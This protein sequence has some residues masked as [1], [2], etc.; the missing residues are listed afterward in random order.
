MTAA[1]VVQTSLGTALNQTNRREEER[2]RTILYRSTNISSISTRRM[3]TL[4]HTSPHSLCRFPEVASPPCAS[5]A[6]ISTCQDG[7][8]LRL[9]AAL[10]SGD[11]SSRGVTELNLSLQSLGSIGAGIL[12]SMLSRRSSRP[13][14]NLCLASAQLGD[15]RV[16]AAALAQGVASGAHTGLSST[17]H[18][19]GEWKSQGAEL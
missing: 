6:P 11:S 5:H 2:D 19:V 10:S 16:G 8:L 13:L 17:F 1:S 7:D 12:A 14:H 4:H 15:V 3:G 18:L 9:C